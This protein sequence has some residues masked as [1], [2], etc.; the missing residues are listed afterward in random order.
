MQTVIQALQLSPV[1]DA[2]ITTGDKPCSA[3]S[4]LSHVCEFKP[5]CLQAIKDA[6]YIETPT[7]IY[8]ANATNGVTLYVVQDIWNTDTVYRSNDAANM[9]VHGFLAAGAC[10]PEDPM[11]VPTFSGDLIVLLVKDTCE[12]K[13]CKQKD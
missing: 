8:A 3:P 10:F 12:N 11:D 6:F 13:Q 9:F 7:V 5:D 1:H 2:L 4:G